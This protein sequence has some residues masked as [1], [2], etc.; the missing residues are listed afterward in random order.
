MSMAWRDNRND[1]AEV[2]PLWVWFLVLVLLGLAMLVVGVIVLS[3]RDIVSI[4][5]LTDGPVVDRR[6]A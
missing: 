2:P 4:L 6:L 1:P 3:G 5:A